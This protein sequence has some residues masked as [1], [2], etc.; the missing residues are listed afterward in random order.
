[1]SV[2]VVS[3]SYGA[4]VLTEVILAWSFKK[5]LNFSVR[6]RC[7]KKYFLKN[8][9]LI[10]TFVVPTSILYGKKY[11]QLV[12]TLYSLYLTKLPVTIGSQIYFCDSAIL[13]KNNEL[14]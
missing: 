12:S 10:P 4:A 6:W 5:V 13:Q 8:L 1:M 3:V 2:C 9:Y 14:L 11:M 7:H